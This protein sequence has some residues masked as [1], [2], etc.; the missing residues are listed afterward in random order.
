RRHT[1]WPRD[2]SS[3]VCSSDLPW[4]YPNKGREIRYQFAGGPGG[5]AMPT[6]SSPVTAVTVF[7]T[8][9]L[10]SATDAAPADPHSELPTIWDADRSEERRVGKEGR[11]REWM[12][13]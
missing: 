8:A 1:R 13:V 4:P 7:L 5:M 12:G 11:V 3:D 10:R 6:H 9:V 2:W